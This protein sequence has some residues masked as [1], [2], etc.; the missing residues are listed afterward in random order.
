MQ[1]VAMI[2][3]GLI[4]AAAMVAAQDTDGDTIPDAIEAQIAT[5]PN[6]AEPL[7]LLW[8]DGTGEADAHK[9]ATLI[10]AGDFTRIWFAP[11][12][13]G[14]WLWKIDLAGE[15]TWPHPSHDVRILYVDADND[16]TTGRPDSGPG[17]DIMFYSDRHDNLIG[18][19]RPMK[20][21]KASDGKSIY[22]VADVDLNQ[23]DGQSVFRMMLL[24]QDI[25]EG[26]GTNRDSMPWIDVRAAGESDREPIEVPVGHALYLPPQSV[27]FVQARVLFDAGAPRAE[28]TF[29]TAL[30]TFPVVEFGPTDAYGSSVTGANSWNNHRIVLDDLEPDR[31]YHYRV[32]VPVRD[33][34]IVSEDATF[35]TARPAPVVGSVARETV[36]LTVD[37]PHTTPAARVPITAGLPFPEGALGDDAHLRLLDGGGRELPVQSEVTARW[38][39]GSV[40]WTLLD[41]VADV[42]AQTAARFGVEYGSQVERTVEAEG[43]TIERDGDTLIVDTG[44]LEATLNPETGGEFLATLDA[45]PGDRL[46]ANLPVAAVCVVDEAGFAS[47]AD[48]PTIE[49]ERAGPLAAVIKVSGAHANA[50]GETLFRYVSR[51]HFTAGSGLVRLQHAVENDRVDQ[52]LTRIDQYMIPLR[53]FPGEGATVTVEGGEDGPVSFPADAGSAVL[54]QDLDNHWSL[55]APG[56][57]REGERGPSAIDVSSD[58]RGLW[59]GLRAFWQKWPSELVWHHEAGGIGVN[60]LPAFEDD[61]Y[62]DLGDAVESDR[63]YYHVRDGGYRLHWGM[64]FTREIWLGFHE[65]GSEATAAWAE[66]LREPL[67]A[68]APTQWYC[69]SG[70]FGDQLPRT[71]GRFVEYEQMVDRIL[72]RLVQLREQN[73]SYG[74]LNYG[75]WWGERGY[76][77][78]NHEYDTP[79]ADMVQF[80]RTGERRF[81]DEACAAAEHMRDVDFIHHAPNPRDVFKTRAH[82][83]F[84]TGGYEPRMTEEERG[85]AYANDGGVTAPLSGHQ[86]NRGLLEHYYMTGEVR[87]R[88]AGMGLG[89][90]MAGPGTVNWTIGHGAERCAA[91]AIYDVLANYEATYDPFYLNAA[92]IMIEDAIRRQTE[93]GHWGFPAGYSQVQPTPI[94]GYAW[95]SGLLI[96][97]LEH[98]NRYA[99]DPRVDEM[100]L[101]AA[102]WL[103][104]EE[105]I[106]ERKGFRSCSCDTFNEITRPGHS[107]WGVADAMAI[108]YELSGD[109][110][111]L[112]LAQMTYAYFIPTAGGMG[113]NYSIALVTSPQLICKLHNA[114]RDDLSTWRWDE[115]F[116]ALVPRV[117]PPGRPLRVLLRTGRPEPVEVSAA[118]GGRTQALTVRPGGAWQLFELDEAPGGTTEITLASGEHARPCTVQGL[119]VGAAQVGDAVGLIAGDEDFLGPALP[120]LGVEAA[121]ISAGDDLSR[122]GTIF[123]GTQACT[124]DA[125]GIR[126]DPGPLLAWLHAG[127][128]VVVSHPNDEAWDPFL[129]GPPLVLQEENAVSGAIVAPEHALF[130]MPT[131][132]A[133]IAGAAMYDSVA[134][135]DDAWQVLA[136]DTEGRPAVLELTLGEGRVLVMVPSFE[137]YVTGALSASDD[138]TARYRAF[139]ENVMAWAVR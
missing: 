135:A 105:F 49:V 109:E 123:L 63:L 38:P 136:N 23:E 112:D 45:G 51:Y 16:R 93:A 82:R 97:M 36:E 10:P 121:P 42:P 17:C 15:T 92:R 6:F 13:R 117:L 108:A 40:K 14:R 5:D 66:Q 8:E 114:G 110:H 3:A 24:Y 99:Q 67:I 22:I 58:G 29:I 75:D 57:H 124:L 77:W 26:Q 129:F 127:G 74:F 1:R 56:V 119:E 9:G 68:Q 83:M 134:Y 86:W 87:S 133:D 137:R 47:I 32:R 37:N 96:T 80:V 7:E 107:A 41:F 52:T 95:C 118:V 11:V 126:S 122:F 21:V 20:S 64:S 73:R 19:T 70:A 50:A 128:R 139:V 53:L 90:F 12:A 94:G 101:R 113:K 120:L 72:D 91:W 98:Y 39:D 79:H 125:A 76:N 100:I 18:W 130:T 65:G 25:R 103:A 69:A 43:L 115:P 44:M 116:E 85:L 33:G 27:D 102:Q 62:A 71:E 104:R 35:S 31:E 34:D 55:T 54:N 132:V 61:R 106:P 131:A 88:E 28:V 60:L 46:A 2:I 89:D 81:F 111:F 4:L 78:G 48:T 84:H 59:V 30:P 138:A